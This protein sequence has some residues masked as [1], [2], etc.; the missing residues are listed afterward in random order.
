MMSNEH[1]V[2]RYIKYMLGE[3]NRKCFGIRRTYQVQ[4]RTVRV[5]AE[6]KLATRDNQYYDE[7]DVKRTTAEHYRR[8]KVLQWM[9]PNR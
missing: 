1:L 9:L 8:R 4:L 7:P 3:E 6:G 5:V 2:P